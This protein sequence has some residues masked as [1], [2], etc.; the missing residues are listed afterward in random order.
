MAK[1]LWPK[2]Q[3]ELVE[4]GYQGKGWKRCRGANCRKLIYWALTPR[5]HLMPMS[6]VDAPPFASDNAAN[7]RWFQPHHIDCEDRARFRRKRSKAARPGR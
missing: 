2:S 1:I 7:E 4:E 6:E 3:S 5:N